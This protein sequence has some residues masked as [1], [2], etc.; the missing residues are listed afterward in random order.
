[1]KLARYPDFEAL[2]VSALVGLA[3]PPLQN[4]ESF[5]DVY[6]PYY[7]EFRAATAP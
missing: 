3:P 6:Q 1:M 2:D 5:V 4:L 7:Y